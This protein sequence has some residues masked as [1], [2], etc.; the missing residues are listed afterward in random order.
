M[1][2]GSSKEEGEEGAAKRPSRLARAKDRA[3]RFAAARGKSK[4][5]AGQQQQEQCAYQDDPGLY[6]DA[7]ATE[8]VTK[9]F[10]ATPSRVMGGDQAQRA[11][12]I[13]STTM[14]RDFERREAQRLLKESPQQFDL[15]WLASALPCAATED[16]KWSQNASTTRTVDTLRSAR[17]SAKDRLK[18][19]RG[20]YNDLPSR[21]CHRESDVDSAAF[22][23]DSNKQLGDFGGGRLPGTRHNPLGVIWNKESSWWEKDIRIAEAYTSAADAAAAR[24]A[25]VG[26]SADIKAHAQKSIPESAPG[27]RGPPIKPGPHKALP[28][29]KT[30]DWENNLRKAL[31]PRRLGFRF[32]AYLFLTEFRTKYLGPPPYAED[33]RAVQVKER[34]ERRVM[35]IQSAFPWLGRSIVRWHTDAQAT[36]KERLRELGELV[37]IPWLY[38]PAEPLAK[39]ALE[40][41]NDDPWSKGYARLVPIY[42]RGT[43]DLRGRLRGK[44]CIPTPSIHPME[45]LS[46]RIVKFI[47]DNNGDGNYENKK[48]FRLQLSTLV[49]GV[50]RQVRDV[51]RQTAEQYSVLVFLLLFF[52][53]ER[54]RVKA[55][56]HGK[57]SLVQLSKA[58]ID[59]QV[60]ITDWFGEDPGAHKLIE[61]EL[62][63]ALATPIAQESFGYTP[64]KWQES[65]RQAMDALPANVPWPTELLVPA[66]ILC[67]NTVACLETSLL[68]LNLVGPKRREEMALLAAAKEDFDLAEYEEA[69]QKAKR[70][71]V[72]VMGRFRDESHWDAVLDHFTARLS[73]QRDPLARLPVLRFMDEPKPSQSRLAR[74]SPALRRKLRFYG[75]TQKQ[76]CASD[77]AGEIHLGF[78]ERGR[79][80]SRAAVQQAVMRADKLAERIQQLRSPPLPDKPDAKKTSVTPRPPSTPYPGARLVIAPIDFMQKQLLG[81][82][83]AQT[84]KLNIVPV[85][86]LAVMF[87]TPGAL[88]ADRWYEG[89]PPAAAGKPKACNCSTF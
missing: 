47:G 29:L 26:M 38:N 34:R 6:D 7:R 66:Q 63:G 48:L 86:P 80:G 19:A 24:T 3:R 62:L 45:T 60:D 8:W 22:V 85:Q 32:R 64:M 14:V 30:P 79:P 5:R 84:K 31:D 25:A 83:A 70:P 55:K 18:T 13:T 56:G 11:L 82:S 20:D 61:K 40:W 71:D 67:F 88:L 36:E 2:G 52:V 10:E 37:Q 59:E 44:V 89:L 65:R 49:S 4:S 87:T 9:D 81:V 51:Y 77:R 76:W 74:I 53:R 43:L 50:A 57:S 42:G 33:P 39:T 54:L 27:S 58:E 41:D 72:Y 1:G 28:E 75:P 17:E 46:T 68:Y 16:A 73:M 23:G 78:Q 69:A 12:E 35:D 21:T 15:L